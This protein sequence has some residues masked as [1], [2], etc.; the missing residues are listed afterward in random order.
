[1]GTA[2]ITDGQLCNV[3]MSSFY[4]VFVTAKVETLK[5]I[6]YLFW[7]SLSLLSIIVRSILLRTTIQFHKALELLLTNHTILLF[8]AASHSPQSALIH[9]Y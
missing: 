8:V 9:N 5:C 3:I 7:L 4:G 2:K 1:M 6:S